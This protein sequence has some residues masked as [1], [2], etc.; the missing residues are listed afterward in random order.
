MKKID[1]NEGNGRKLTIAHFMPWSGM[2]GV[3]I[4]TL[5][6]ADAI[7][8]SYRNVAFCLEDAVELK[9]SFQKMGIETVTYVPPTPSLRHGARFYK[10]SRRVAKQIKDSGADI[11]HFS[12]EKAANHNSLAAFLAGTRNVCH[13]RV[14]YPSLEWRQRLCLLPVDSFIFVS[15]EAKDTFAMSLPERKTRV[16]YDAVEVP[17]VDHQASNAEVR[18][19]FGIP[20]ESP[21]VGMV[22]RVSAQKDY[23]TLATA[24]VEV[25]AKHPEAKFFIAGDNSLV[26]LNR[27]HYQEVAK[28]LR[29]LGIE[30]RFIF[31][32]HRRDVP[33]LIAAMD[34]CVLC[35]HRE[36]FPLSILEVM[37]MGKPVIATS[38][39]GIPEIVIPEVTGYLHGHGNSKEL[40]DAIN[41]L[42]ENPVKTRA[43]GESAR[44]HVREHYSREGYVADMTRAYEDVMR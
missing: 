35:T 24:A 15:K 1:C 18:R 14:S 43:L 19:E 27:K 34:I 44:R 10:E 12:D 16:I 5:R 26:D 23:F 40:A 37:A 7:K 36:G 13:L 3:E 25:L 30:D 6:L 9:E 29:E 38:V 42:I 39:G 32:G 2:G 8:D 4:A 31:T 11:V 21:V 33:R 17:K 28:R 41:A 22:A 20:M